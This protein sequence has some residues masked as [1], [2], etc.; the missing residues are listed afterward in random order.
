MKRLY[1]YDDYMLEMISEGIKNDEL[2]L[3]ISNELRNLLLSIRS[4]PISKDILDQLS[5]IGDKSKVTYLDIDDSDPKKKDM[6]SY[7]N[8][9]KVIDIGMKKVF[10]DEQLSILKDKLDDDKMNSIHQYVTF[11]K[12]EFFNNKSRA[13]TKIGRLIGKIFPGKYDQSGK[14]GQDIESFVNMF[15]AARDNTLFE[16]VEGEEVKYWYNGEQYAGEG[17]PLNSSCMKYDNCED[18][19]N[20]YSQNKHKVSLL[21]LKDTNDEDKIRGRA[22]IWKLDTPS[23]RTFMDR[24]Y[25]VYDS[26]VILFKEYAKDNGWLYKKNQN[27]ESGGPWVDTTTDNQIRTTLVVNNLHDRGDY[28]YMDT[29]KYFNGSTITNQEGYLSGGDI[30]MLTDTEGSFES[31][32]EWSDFYD[33]YV[34]IDDMTYCEMGDDY[35]HDNDC[36]YSDYYNCSIADNYAE[37]EMVEMD[38]YDGYSDEYREEGDYITTHEGNTCDEDYATDHFEWSN[39]HDEWLEDSVWSDY[40]DSDIAE[41]ESVEVYTDVEGDDTDWR[42][43]YEGDGYWWEWDYDDEKYDNDITEEQLRK[44]HDLDI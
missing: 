28:P 1:S 22:L 27:M 23:G 12:D 7:M 25:T 3:I 21:I 10:N 30:K 44:H 16:I 24:I 26:D 19:I 9:N 43:D 37:D 18:F 32:G 4:H 5:D 11:N 6:V 8:S 36:Y 20:F 38:H 34:D 41:D 14:P 40:H 17:G 13:K 42:I 39:Y 29:M 2:K 33:D 15:K 35:R 31:I